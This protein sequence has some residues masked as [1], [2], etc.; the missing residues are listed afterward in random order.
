[1]ESEG[2][3]QYSQEP[4]INFQPERAEPSPYSYIQLI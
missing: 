3:L 4:A 1:M 2:S